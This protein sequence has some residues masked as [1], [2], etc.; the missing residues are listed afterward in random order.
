MLDVWPLFLFLIEITFPT[1]VLI[2]G[3][4]DLEPFF[5]LEWNNA[6]PWWSGVQISS[7]DDPVAFGFFRGWELQPYF[8]HEEQTLLVSHMTKKLWA[9]AATAIWSDHE[10]TVWGLVFAQ[11]LWFSSTGSILLP[12]SSRTKQLSTFHTFHAVLPGYGLYSSVLFTF[13][14]LSES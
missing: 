1:Q 7:E 6:R 5:G 10:P 14:T 11:S 2:I 8:G 12:R 3:Q 13:F 4:K 9:P